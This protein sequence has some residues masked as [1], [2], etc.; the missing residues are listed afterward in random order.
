MRSTYL[1]DQASSESGRDSGQDI[2]CPNITMARVGHGL[3][4]HDSYSAAN[5]WTMWNRKELGG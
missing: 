2:E 3:W 5:D 4:N 1:K